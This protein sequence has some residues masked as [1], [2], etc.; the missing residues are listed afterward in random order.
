MW[1][2]EETE[3]I[4]YVGILFV[5]CL[6]AFGNCEYMYIYRNYLVNSG[7]E[8]PRNIPDRHNFQRLEE[9]SRNME[10]TMLII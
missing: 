9:H 5:K 6:E 7:Q 10:V 2:D 3:E 8:N 1:R 4:T